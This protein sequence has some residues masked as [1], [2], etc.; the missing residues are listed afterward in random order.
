MQD[1]LQKKP[2]TVLNMKHY[3]YLTSKKLL[4]YAIFYIYSLTFSKSTLT[5]FFIKGHKITNSLKKI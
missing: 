5:E 1:K 4:T 3:I 2:T